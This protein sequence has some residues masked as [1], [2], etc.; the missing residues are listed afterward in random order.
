MSLPGRRGQVLTST[1]SPLPQ[2]EAS[3]GS[4]PVRLT[5]AFTQLLPPRS[6]QFFQRAYFRN[7]PRPL[8]QGSKPPFPV[9]I[10]IAR[11][12]VPPNQA[13]VFQSSVYRVYEASG[14][15]ID[16]VVEVEDGRTV[17][18]FGFSTQIG[19]RGLID[20]ST[21]VT[22]NGDPVVWN[23]AQQLGATQPPQVGAGRIYPFTG[24]SQGDLQ[25]FA[26]YAQ[27][28]EGI[29]LTAWVMRAPPFDTRKFSVEVSGYLVGQAHLQKIL[30][31]L[32][33]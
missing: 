14:I 24:K 8:Q 21:N 11:I 13:L 26:F 22:A 7:Y 6:F 16:D 4:K 30:D 15:G 5:H 20:F 18:V 1:G 31:M 10:N 17:G 3:G 28:G 2:G 32:A 23:P 12:E 19:N 29:D 25:N 27:S 9:P 33:V